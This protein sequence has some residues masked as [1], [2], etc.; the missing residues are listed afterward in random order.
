MQASLDAEP[1]QTEEAAE[2]TDAI[3]I[4]V[5]EAVSPMDVA[6]DMTEGGKTE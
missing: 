3:G 1:V 2:A 6:A 4:E 5:E